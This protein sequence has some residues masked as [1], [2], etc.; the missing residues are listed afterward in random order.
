MR[1]TRPSKGPMFSPAPR[2]ALVPATELTADAPRA[3]SWWKGLTP[4]E[5]AT[6]LPGEAH[7]LEITKARLNYRRIE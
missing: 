4:A 2:T 1:K 3:G 5:F 6:Q 7:R